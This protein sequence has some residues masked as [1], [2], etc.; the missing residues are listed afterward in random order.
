MQVTTAGIK[1][2][3]FEE[4]S[5]EDELLVNFKLV[6]IYEVRGT[7][8]TPV[9]GVDQT[10]A[11]TFGEH[12][13][14][15]IS[16]NINSVAQKLYGDDCFESEDEWKKERKVSSPFIVV[17]Y[18]PPNDYTLKGGYRK[19]EDKNILTYDAFP[20]AKE[21]LQKW[22]NEELPSII[23]ALTVKMS[24]PD[25]P[26][27]LK[28]ADRFPFART[29]DGQTLFDTKLSGSMSGYASRNIELSQLNTALEQS[30]SLYS[31][32]DEKT[33]R[34]IHMALGE[35]DTFKQFLYYF[36]FIERYTHSVYKKINYETDG[37]SLVN[38]PARLN[39]AA[40]AFMKE[41]QLEAKNLKQRFIW[42]SILKWN[43]ISDQD[44]DDFREIKKI[45]DK[46]SHGENVNISELPI[47]KTKGL[48][49][50][51]LGMH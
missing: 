41:R 21:K 27:I 7:I 48:A 26:T 5:S 39:I 51:L 14:V 42:C 46:I 1:A 34:H 45:R 40:S 32:L 3:G 10:E 31:T 24:T 44:I 4:Y 30:S 23:T 2:M 6:R 18:E 16:L 47:N 38:I 43:E 20:E 33:S 35:Q 17:F 50:K 49:L 11:V 9:D 15:V 36:L 12:C 19:I 25:R 37:S 22:E 28:A 29:A 13:S 8:F